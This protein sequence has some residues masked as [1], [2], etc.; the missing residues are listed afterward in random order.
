MD[1]SSIVGKI[2][3]KMPTAVNHF[4]EE[5]KK[6]RTGRA[7]PDMLDSLVV[8]VY[9]MQLPLNKTAS[10]SAPEAQLLQIT[11][12]DPGTLQ[13][14]A[15]AIR[16]NQSLGLN[17]TDDGRVIRIP[18]PTLTEE[19]RRELAKMIGVKQEECMVTLR[20]IRHEAMEITSQAKKDKA[21]GE[22][23]V[24]RLERHID[25]AMTKARGDADVSARAKEQ[26][27]M[28]L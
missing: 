15:N 8:E 24:K 7:H 17:P 3:D 22:D 18:I 11:P 9:G 5:L 26:D 6:L 21:I 14:I 19:R 12:F 27:I 2:L 20:N 28:S 1:L 25:E 4:R 13:S 23:E 16:T 10:V